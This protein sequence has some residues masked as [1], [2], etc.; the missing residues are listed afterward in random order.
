M[1]KTICLYFTIC[2][3]TQISIAQNT[4]LEIYSSNRFW[5]SDKTKAGDAFNF[6]NTTNSKYEYI[7]FIYADTITITYNK[8][9]IVFTITKRKS[10][11]KDAT[12]YF[13]SSSNGNS[14]LVE[15]DSRKIGNKQ[16]Y[17][18]ELMRIDKYGI[19]QSLTRFDIKKL[20]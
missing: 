12:G 15:V 20:K 14:F 19:A 16:D 13:V 9:K 3:I 17:D 10:L 7:F 8:Q 5:K 18:I 1:K 6:K 11:F 2:L 4:P